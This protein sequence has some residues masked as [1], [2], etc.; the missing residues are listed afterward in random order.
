MNKVTKQNSG[1][2]LSCC[3][4]LLPSS[5]SS[6]SFSIGKRTSCKINSLRRS[7]ETC[8]RVSINRGVSLLFG[9]SPYSW[10]D[11]L[12]L[13]WSLLFSPTSTLR[14]LHFYPSTPFTSC[15]TLE[16]DLM[17]STVTNASNSSMKS[18]LWSCFITASSSQTLSQ[19]YKLNSIW[20]WASYPFWC[21]W[22]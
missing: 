12:C 2:L 20:V 9:T 21:L 8:T 22:S 16:Q 11:D 4:Y 10:S 18:A 17:L 5:S 1:Y 15:I 7:L 19:I 14:L 13:Q 6:H 3:W